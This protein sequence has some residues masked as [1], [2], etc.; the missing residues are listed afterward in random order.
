MTQGETCPP[1]PAMAAAALAHA[2]QAGVAALDAV[3]R[4][5][6]G[7]TPHF[8]ATYGAA[9]VVFMILIGT[10]RGVSGD[11]AFGVSWVAFGAICTWF[12]NRQSVCWR[13]FDRLV[14][15]SFIAY[16]VLWAIAGGVGFNFFSHQA[17]YWVPAALVVSAPLFAGAW[18]LVWR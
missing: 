7:W 1:D 4:A 12:S 9:S 8:L 10:L 18:R 11:I 5:G 2:N 15:V 3:R 6:S 14:G 17:A 13:G 16:F